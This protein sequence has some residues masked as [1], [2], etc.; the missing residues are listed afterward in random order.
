MYKRPSIGNLPQ[1]TLFKRHSEI[2]GASGEGLH[3]DRR[4]QSWPI[5]SS[6]EGNEMQIT[7]THILFFIIA[8][9]VFVDWI[10]S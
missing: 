7:D 2:Q 8:F 3:K 10:I 6:T 5:R 4:N 1:A 9:A